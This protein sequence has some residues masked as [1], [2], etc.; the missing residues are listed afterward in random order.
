MTWNWK[1][2][3]EKPMKELD[4]AQLDDV[5]FVMALL[6]DRYLKVAESLPKEG[7]YLDGVFGALDTTKP[8]VEAAMQWLRDALGQAESVFVAGPLVEQGREGSDG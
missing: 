6:T 7:G 1:V 4:K 8:E 2:K 5:V 3:V